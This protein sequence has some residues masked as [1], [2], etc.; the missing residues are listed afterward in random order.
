VWPRPV[1]GGHGADAVTPDEIEGWQD[2]RR[3]EWAYVDYE[4]DPTDDEP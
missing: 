1:A 3:D 2:A 4:P